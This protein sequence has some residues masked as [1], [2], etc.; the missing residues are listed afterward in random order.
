MRDCDLLVIGLGPAG[1]RAA[2]EAAGAGRSVIAL[3][4]KKRVGLPV[5]CAEFIPL[6]LSGYAPP[7]TRTQEVE[8]MSTVLPSGDSAGRGF[9]GLMIRRDRFDQALAK[10]AEEAGAVLWTDTSLRAIDPAR[11]IAQASTAT[12]LREIRYRAIV[13]AD[14]PLSQAAACLGL[15]RLRVVATRQYT[16]PLEHPHADT[17]VWLSPEYPGGYAWLFPKGDVANLGVGMDPA[18]EADLKEPLDALHKGLVAAGRVGKEILLRTGGPIPIG[19]LRERL[20]VGETVFA[21]DAA[22]LTHPVSGAGIAQAVTSGEAAGRAVSRWLGGEADA[23]RD[24]E[25]EIREQ[26]E[27]SIERGL[28]ARRRMA[29]VWKRRSADDAE[30]RKGWISFGEYYA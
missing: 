18:L 19:G 2:A 27:A 12:G 8:G 25:D 21:G 23:L 4:R 20:V 15:A 6:P 16:V 3:E 1:A 24:Y 13:A 17:C 5:Q 30:H 9:G 7:E 11:R 28:A 26:Y 29:E 10:R 22:G 14:G